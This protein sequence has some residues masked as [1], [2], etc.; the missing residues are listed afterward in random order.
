MSSTTDPVLVVNAGSHSLKLAV[1]TAELELVHSTTIDAAPDSDEA[2]AGL[3]DF[4]DAAPDVSA[5]GHRIV[6]G[7]PDLTR[8][9]VL[10][11]RV[12]AT[13]QQVVTL[14]PQHLPPALA[15]VRTCRKHLPDVVQV[16]CLDTAFHARLPEAARTY[17][18][19]RRWREHFGVR[20]YGFHG[21]SYSWALARA[22][23]LLKRDV[24]DLQL[25]MTHLGG[26]A[27]VCAVRNGVSVSTSMG[28]TPLEGLVMSRRSGT[29]DPGMLLWLQSEHG[30][31]AADVSQALE[32]ESGLL[33]LSDGRSGDTR[34]LVAA[35]AGGDE[36]STL[37]MDVFTLR[38]RQE[39]AAAAAS[40]D[41]LDAVVFTGEI[42]ADQ[43][44]VRRDVCAGLTVL[45]LRG[46]L[47][48]AQDRDHVLSR[49]GVA[50]VLVH[51]DE[52]R[53]IALETRAVLAGAGKTRP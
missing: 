12:M 52:Q 20:R 2:A 11:E 17:A 43:P 31:S 47:D 35:A 14:A 13:L 44:E 37:A 23:E 46:D 24:E 42:G 29:V 39:L 48:P 5:V 50:V 53:Q 40:L 36:V 45:G 7:G 22:G 16:A 4:L 9:C 27:S 34:E 6:H 15:A 32:H 28:L 49:S 41:R 25:V 38:I 33:G 21:L 10:D 1:V 18:V 3:R 51:P 19:P 8:A 26:G 30:L